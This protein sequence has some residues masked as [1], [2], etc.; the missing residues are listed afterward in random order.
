MRLNPRCLSAA[1]AL[2]ALALATGAS[3]AP[4]LTPA[5]ADVALHDGVFSARDGTRIVIPTG[6]AG[7][8]AAAR[9][10]SE[11]TLKAG[12]PRLATAE[13]AA[14][15]GA[16]AFRR[17]PVKLEGA[18]A[19]ALDVTPAGVT[20]TAPQDAGFMRGAA[21]LWQLLTDAEK[22]VL[23]AMTLNDAPRYSWRGLMLDSARHY[24]SPEFI[25]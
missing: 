22:G 8:R 5:A 19:Y 17:G 18:E 23:P 6:D 24:Q 1:S 10:L 2:I 21:S 9:F 13:G 15:K 25:K 3:A 7:A 4:A 20:L 11:L 12:G 16:I 14:A